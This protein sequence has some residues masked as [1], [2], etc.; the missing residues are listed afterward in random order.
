MK[1][2]LDSASALIAISSFD[3]AAVSGGQGG[4]EL[5]GRPLPN[6]PVQQQPPQPPPVQPNLTCP[7]GTSPN[8]LSAT[9][10]V[11]VNAPAVSG[12]INGS[13]QSFWCT[14]VTR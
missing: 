12:R 14:P 11:S 3:L 10:D 6:L 5:H 8:W 13:F 2:N 7:E 9:G 1:K 4:A